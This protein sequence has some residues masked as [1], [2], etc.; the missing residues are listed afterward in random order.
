MRSND[1]YLGLP[2]DVFSFTM[3][4]EIVARLLGVEMGDYTHFAG[5][6]HLYDEHADDAACLLDRDGSNRRG[7]ISSYAPGDSG[8]SIEVFLAQAEIAEVPL[9]G[10]I[11]GLDPYW[12][13]PL[14]GCLET[15][16]ERTT[17]VETTT[18]K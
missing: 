13:T 6:L 9:Y 4:Q 14:S 15:L 11:D 17:T 10:D 2:H 8:P 16:T 12:Q 18:R 7:R 5:S 1:V 3:I